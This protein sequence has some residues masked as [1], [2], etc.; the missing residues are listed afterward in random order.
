MTRYA[1]G[2]KAWG[3]CARS[4]KRML[5]KDMVFDGRYPN[6]R[7]DPDWWEGKHPQETLPKV[8]DA[9][10]LFHPAPQNLR[11]P[12]TPE[13]SGEL[14]GNAVTLS[15]SESK[16]GVAFVTEYQIYRAIGESESVLLATVPVVRDELGAATSARV[17]TDANIESGVTYRY[18]VIAAAGKAGESAPSNIVE[19]E[20]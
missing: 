3:E 20:A 12:T 1:P 2:K 13:L 9:I 16:S 17:Y 11:P 8:S 10:A 4:G 15:W 18:H 7:V 19:I 14:A 5:L 6:L